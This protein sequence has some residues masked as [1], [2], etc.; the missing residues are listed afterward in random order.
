[1]GRR[2]TLNQTNTPMDTEQKP[3]FKSAAIAHVTKIYGSCKANDYPDYIRVDSFVAGCDKIWTD[4]VTPLQSQLSEAEKRI[5][6]LEEQLI[7]SLRKATQ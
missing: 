3:D 1:M 6:E 5:K 7:N 2:M 4:Y